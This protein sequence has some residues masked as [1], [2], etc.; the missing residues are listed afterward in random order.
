VNT[1]EIQERPTTPVKNGEMVDMR[2]E[3][4]IAVHIF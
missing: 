2:C 1:A 4:L 3:V